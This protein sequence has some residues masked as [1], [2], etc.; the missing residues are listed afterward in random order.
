MSIHNKTL[1]Q[2]QAKKLRLEN[3]SQFSR[4]IKDLHHLASTKSQPGIYNAPYAKQLPKA[5]NIPIETH[6]KSAF[7]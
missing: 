7:K 4:I 2:A 6:I 3:E 5:F 1:R